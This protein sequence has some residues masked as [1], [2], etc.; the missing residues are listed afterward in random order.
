MNLIDENEEKEQ[1]ESK[2]KTL[3]IILISID[4]TEKPYNDLKNEVQKETTK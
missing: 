1:A 2:K 4:I 3:K